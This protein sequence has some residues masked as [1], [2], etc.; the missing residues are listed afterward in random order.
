MSQRNHGRGRERGFS[1]LQLIITIAIAGIVSVFALVGL[2]RSRENIRL[3]SSVRQLAS[4]MEKARLDAIRRHSPTSVVFNSTTSYTV[5]MDFD[6]T[7]TVGARSFSLESGVAIIT[8]SLPSIGFDW[9]GRTSACTITFAMQNSRGEQTWVDVSDAGDVTVNSDVDVLPTVSFTNVNST[10]DI[11]TGTV[12][13]GTTPHNN[14]VDCADDAGVGV[15]PPPITGTG[16]SGC[17]MT[18]TP[19]A[20]TINKGG[21]STGTVTLST[22]GS[23]TYTITP[24]G[25]NNLSVSPTSKTIAGGGSTG[26]S[27]R[28]LN[29][30]RG[31]FAVN[32]S[33]SCT[34]VTVA[35]K[36]TN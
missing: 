24:S 33:S 30:T 22:T 16:A 35:V 26:F 15:T 7:G 36:V 19:S 8:N 34:T 18:G 20:L 27:I 9:R 32:F 25:P 21:G 14:T 1:L 17:T 12:V 23:S 5:T 10:A 11:A 6:G 28:S 3:Q 4:Y 13:S 31:T 2:A 29:N